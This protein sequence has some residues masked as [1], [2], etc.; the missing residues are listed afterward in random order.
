MQLS[1]CA[2]SGLCH[3]KDAVFAGMLLRAGSI[4]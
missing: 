1:L 4:E 3:F 2:I